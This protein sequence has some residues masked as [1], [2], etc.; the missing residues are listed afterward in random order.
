MVSVFLSVFR[1]IILCYIIYLNNNIELCVL[2]EKEYKHI[3]SSSL[4]NIFEEILKCIHTGPG[5]GLK[6]VLGHTFYSIPVLLS[7]VTNPDKV[8]QPPKP[9]VNICKSGCQT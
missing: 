3:N 5:P 1:F 8:L 9:T 2:Q 6:T 7:Q 4:V